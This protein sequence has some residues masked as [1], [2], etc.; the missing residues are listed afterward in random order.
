MPIYECDCRERGTQ[1]E[2]LVFPA[3][4]LACP[5]CQSNDFAKL[6]S[7]VVI[8]SDGTGKANLAAGGKAKQKAWRDQKDAEIEAIKH[9]DD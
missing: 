1:F 6:F 5:S 8:C 2:L 4:T 3:T 9:R 7:M